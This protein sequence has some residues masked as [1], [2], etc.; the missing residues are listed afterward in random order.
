MIAHSDPLNESMTRQR[1]ISDQSASELAP[2]LAPNQRVVVGLMATAALHQLDLAVLMRGLADETK[3]E[4]IGKFADQLT[5]GAHPLD[6][7]AGIPNLFPLPCWAALKSARADGSL[8]SFYRSWLA[9]TVDDRVNFTRHEDTNAAA[10]GRL[11][12]RTAFCLW[13]MSI[14][15]FVVI[16]EHQKMYEEFGIDM[17]LTMKTFMSFGRWFAV[18]FFPVVSFI[19]V[20]TSLYI[21]CFRRSILNNYIRRWLPGR[22]RQI[23]LPKSVLRRK[24]MAWDLLAYEG[25]DKPESEIVDW[26]ANIKAGELS[27]KEADVMKQASSLETKAWLLRNM[28][29]QKHDAR[30]LRF[31][32]VVSAFIFLFQAVLAIFI[33]L[34]TFSIFSMLIKLMQSVV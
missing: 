10:I 14:I 8:H 12:L 24:L 15:L 17:N 1:M 28:A 34:A 30:K 13:F 19:I 6:V 25:M 23:D 2:L 11:G 29:D 18:I 3:S 27:R 32:F 31:S 20:M 33:V 26:D 16:P 4:S 5:P 21:L 22:W 7:A 9:Q